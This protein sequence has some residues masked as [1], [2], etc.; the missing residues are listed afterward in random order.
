MRVPNRKVTTHGV[1]RSRKQNQVGL[2]QNPEQIIGVKTNRVYSQIARVSRC[3]KRINERAILI[4]ALES[5]IKEVNAVNKSIKT[6]PKY[7]SMRATDVQ[8]CFREQLE[9]LPNDVFVELP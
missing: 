4:K 9:R 2:F 3:P 7:V 5:A 6:Q 1:L 8:L